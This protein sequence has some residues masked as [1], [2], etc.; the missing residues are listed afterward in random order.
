MTDYLKR[1]ATSLG[2][3]TEGLIRTEEEI[4]EEQMAMQQQQMMQQAMPN[5]VNA[6]GKM[7]QDNP[8]AVEQMAS[9]AAQQMQ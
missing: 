4:Q 9:A 8:E 7:A 5:V 2:I 1:R 6:A 3:D